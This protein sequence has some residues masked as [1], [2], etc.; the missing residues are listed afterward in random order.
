MRALD[1]VRVGLQEENDA[2]RHVTLSIGNKLRSALAA[3]SGEEV[4]RQWCR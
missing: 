3:V 4:R 2:F 1:Q